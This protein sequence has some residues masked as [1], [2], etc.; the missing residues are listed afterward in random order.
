MGH[1]I[2]QDFLA[3]IAKRHDLLNASCQC[4]YRQ[5]V[6]QVS[7]DRLILDLTHQGRFDKILNQIWNY[8]A[9]W[10]PM[11]VSQCVIKQKIFWIQ[12]ILLE[13]FVR[14]YQIQQIWNEH[15][16]FSNARLVCRPWYSRGGAKKERTYI[17]HHVETYAIHIPSSRQL[18]LHFKPN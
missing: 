13:E 16:L 5:T 11:Q 12:K 6:K 7:T 8:V 4:E 15:V 10:I 1:D 2:W 3:I 14:K 17:L 18:I 9:Y